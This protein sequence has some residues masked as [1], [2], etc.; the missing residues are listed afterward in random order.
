VG[1]GA[2]QD[3]DVGPLVT[4]AQQQR[5][6]GYLD[7]GVDEGA[8]IAAQAALP[9]D[10]RLA[11]GFYV[12][13]TVLADVTPDMRVATEEIFGPVVSVIRFADEEEAVRIANGTAFGLVGAVF[14]RDVERALRVSRKIRAGAVFVNNYVRLS[15]GSGFGGIGASGSGREHA[16][17]TLAEYGYTKT[18]RLTARRQELRYW[19]AAAR[20]LRT[21][22][23][24]N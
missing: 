24:E 4:R 20:V 21:E 1:D 23:K 8:R 6:L 17:E 3:T 2:E 11:D 13:P 19:P 7:I 18:I 22:K 9:D 16:Q 15:I 5:V 14:S 10:P 12:A